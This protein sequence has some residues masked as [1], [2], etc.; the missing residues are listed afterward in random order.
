MK[1][2]FTL[3]EM[4]AALAIL[5]IL[6]ALALPR[7][8][9]WTDRRAVRQAASEVASFYGRA[10]MAAVFSGRHVRVEFT[11]DT[12]R[13]R[14]READDSTFLSLPGP[15]RHG[16]ALEASREAIDVAPNGLGWGAANTKIL[17]WRGA[18]SESLTTSRLGRLKRWP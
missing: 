9:G 10:R 2:G 8:A 4:A 6:A 3:P 12:L 1:T 16:V 7:L 14:S 11:A 5:A 17:L 13:A 15:A 18:A